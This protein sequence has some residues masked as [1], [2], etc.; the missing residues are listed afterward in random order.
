[1]PNTISSQDYYQSLMTQSVAQRNASQKTESLGM[2]DF[3]QL[4]VAQLQNQDM[5]N[6]VSNTEFVAQ[7]A[8]FSSM[9]AMTELASLTTSNYAVSMIGKEVTAAMI[10]SNGA[11]EK[12]TGVVTGVS[13]FDGAPKVYIGDREFDLANIMI[14]GKNP[15]AATTPETEES[16]KTEPQPEEETEQNPDESEEAESEVPSV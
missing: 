1:M 8:Q 7:L 4:M 14:V 13:L 10:G 11:M 6:P 16:G 15:A 3:L 12:T 2:Q 9:Q 5:M